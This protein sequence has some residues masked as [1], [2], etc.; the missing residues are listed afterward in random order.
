MAETEPSKIIDI[1][2]LSQSLSKAI[3][4]R[5]QHR[6]RPPDVKR[7]GPAGLAD[8]VMNGAFPFHRASAASP[9]ETGLGED[10]FDTL[11][12][13]AYKSIHDV[14]HHAP[15]AHAA[16]KRRRTGG[17]APTRTP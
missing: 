13:L 8:Y 2:I 6:I 16:E 12:P 5:C 17:P 15:I 10:F 1:R 3:Q 14:T 7:A 9:D 4:P 11:P